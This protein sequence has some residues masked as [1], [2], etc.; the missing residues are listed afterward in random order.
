MSAGH[1]VPVRRR[2]AAAWTLALGMTVV[3]AVAPLVMI[4]AVWAW[5]VLDSGFL[6]APIQPDPVAAFTVIALLLGLLVLLVLVACF[7]WRW[8]ITTRAR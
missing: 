4:A 1:P 6:G 7:T 8:L 2:R 5:F 3:A